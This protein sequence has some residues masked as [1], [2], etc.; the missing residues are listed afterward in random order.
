M[1]QMTIH[2]CCKCMFQMFQLFQMY[3]KCL[4]RCCIG[5]TRKEN[6][7]Q[8]HLLWI[9]VF[10]DQQD[11]TGLMCLRVLVFSLIGCKRD[12]DEGFARYHSYP[13]SKPI[14]FKL[15]RST[16]HSFFYK[17]VI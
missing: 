12:L 4:S 5:Y 2:V 8:A 9:L 1:L 17:V 11:Q 15:F 14:W 10:D 16:A 6:G 7:P 13:W 3:C